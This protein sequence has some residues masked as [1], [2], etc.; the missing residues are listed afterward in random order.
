MERSSSFRGTVK[1]SQQHMG[2]E[3]GRAQGLQEGLGGK[4]RAG[5]QRG[6]G[7]GSLQGGDWLRQQNHFQCCLLH[8][9]HL[10]F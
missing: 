3:E 7:D 9:A 8:V 1:S 6:G 2:E 10:S 4:T 5:T